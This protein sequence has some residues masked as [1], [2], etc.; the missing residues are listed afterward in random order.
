MTSVAALVALSLGAVLEVPAGAPLAPALAAARPGDVVRLGPGE[1]A[2]SLGDLSALRVEGAGA[3]VTR[4]VAPEAADGA[5]IRGAVTLAG[6]SLEAGP[7]RCA[8]R[9]LGGDATLEDVAVVGGSCAVF[10]E[11]GR[12]AAWRVLLRGGYGLLMSGGEVRLEEANVRGGEAG[13][14]LLGGALTVLRST[15]TGPSREAGV[16]VSRGTAVLEAVVVRAPGPSGLSVSQGGTI[17]GR[18]V[19]VAGAVEQGGVLGACV[20]VLRGTVR[21]DGATLVGCAGAAVEAAGGEVRLRGVDATGGAAGCVVLVNG[22]TGWL[23]GNVCT[24]PGPGLVL[25]GPSRATLVA[26]R[27]RTLPAAW[28]DC[29]GGARVDLGR[30]E[31]LPPPC[32]RAP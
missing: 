15:V 16:T 13:I 7:S 20:E 4:V 18:D 21:L 9:V 11:R 10:V 32:A 3:G 2:G 5:R 29:D 24:G 27:W 19:T 31:L 12:V 8:L 30:G 26:N 17:E 25:A 22:A 1:H 6:L 14:A 28:I 23:E